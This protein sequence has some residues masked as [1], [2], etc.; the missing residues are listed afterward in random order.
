MKAKEIKA[1]FPITCIVT[2]QHRD[3]AMTFGGLH[4][5]GDILLKETLP[6]ELHEDI[7]WGLSLG[8]VKG[9]AIETTTKVNYKGILRTISLYLDKTFTGNEVTFTLR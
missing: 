5:I 3:L 6:K 7:F 2:P 4:Y 8:T 9:V 1:L